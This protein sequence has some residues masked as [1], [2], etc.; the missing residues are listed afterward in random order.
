[1][2]KSLFKPSQA[3][4]TQFSR[5]LRQVAKMS[6]HIV[7][8]HVGG[9]DHPTGLKQVQRALE[10][11]SAL[12]EP[13]ARTQSLKMLERV[14]NTNRRAYTQRGSTMSKLLKEMSAGPIGVTIMELQR[15]QV[16]LIKSIP[17]KAA[18]RVNDLATRAVYEG[19]RAS[20]IVEDLLNSTDVS[21]SEA[22]NLAISSVAWANASIVEARARAVG[23]TGY[24]W[25]TSKDESVRPSHKKMEGKYIE[26]A[27]PPTLSDG[28]TGHA[29]KFPRC[30]CWQDV[31]FAD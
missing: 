14:N 23:G 12:I 3:I 17:L 2:K 8:M 16:K 15:E 22:Q 18:V 20:E 31:Q 19:K 27:S 10:D 9:I 28:T 30:R 5:A 29:G 11:Y 24:F 7:E 6:G 4:E 26:Y 25:R 21:E 13:W 1:L